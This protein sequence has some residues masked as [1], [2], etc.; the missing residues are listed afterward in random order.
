MKY[1]ISKEQ[2]ARVSK[3]LLINLFGNITAVQNSPD[4]YTELFDKNNNNFADIW[5]FSE[6]RT[7]KGVLCKNKLTL[8]V[9]ESEIID[10]FLPIIRKKTFTKVFFEYIYQ[11][12]KIKCDCIEFDY[13]FEYHFDDGE[14]E[15]S[16]K[17]KEYFYNKKSAIKKKK[18]KK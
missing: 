8:H 17:S 15:V 14:E 16:T 12:T 7:K 4:T 1:I 5:H 2:F 18:K 11:Q 10:S 6:G 13:E 9:G 3:K